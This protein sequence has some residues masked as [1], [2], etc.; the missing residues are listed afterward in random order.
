MST[1]K[2]DCRRCTNKAVAADGSIYCVPM[3]AGKPATY[4]ESGNGGKDF[5]FNCS[6]YTTQAMQIVIYEAIKEAK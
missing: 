5:V 1:Y 3:I 6:G 2:Y 4:I